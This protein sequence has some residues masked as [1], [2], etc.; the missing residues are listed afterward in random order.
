MVRRF[1]KQQDV[2]LRQKQACQAET[3]LLAAREFLGFQLPCVP[4]ETETLE[5]RFGFRRVFKTTFAFELVLKIAVTREHLFQ[6]F[7]RVGHAM[8]KLVHFVLNLLKPAE[9]GERRFVNRRARL[10]MN[11]LREQAKPQAAR[12]HDVAAVGR[13]FSGDEPKDCRL[14]CAVATD[15]SDVLARI[16]L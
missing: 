2:R 16:D 9:R 14:A 7:A 13:F 3:I 8:L 6:I 15:K 4:L 10:E 12:P 11:M 5:N 1:V